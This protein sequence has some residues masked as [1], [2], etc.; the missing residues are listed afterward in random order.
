MDEEA[1]IFRVPSQLAPSLER[2][3]GG[4][5]GVDISLNPVGTDGLN[6]I[7]ILRD[8]SGT[9]RFP[10]K[11]ASLPTTVEIQKTADHVHLVKSGM[12]SRVLVVY[13]QRSAAAGAAMVDEESRT[14]AETI[15]VVLDPSRDAL[16]DVCDVVADPTPGSSERVLDSGLT[17]P[18][19]HAVRRRFRKAQRY[20]ARYDKQLVEEA[21]RVLL[22]LTV[23]DAYEHCVEELVDAEPFMAP[24]FRNGGDNVTICYE[25]GECVAAS[26]S[27]QFDSPS[28]PPGM[29]ASPA[30]RHCEGHVP[31]AAKPRSR[32]LPRRKCVP[33]THAPDGLRNYPPLQLRQSS[34]ASS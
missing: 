9:R 29:P 20:I 7:F 4:D 13:E 27:V 24:W 22:D 16:G 30:H 31:T 2:F 21:E 19:Q 32:S 26:A 12:I 18:M 23:H 33:R 5:A 1:V 11:F 14:S 17:P 34:S 6:F 28:L 25:D 8:E 10:A 15:D 3:V